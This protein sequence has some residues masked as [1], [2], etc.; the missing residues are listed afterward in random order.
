[1]GG[2]GDT[3]RLV[4]RSF[5]GGGSLSEG[6]GLPSGAFRRAGGEVLWGVGLLVGSAV[7][8]SFACPRLRPG[9][10]G[11]VGFYEVFEDEGVVV[12]E[13]VFDLEDALSEVDEV[14]VEGF[15]FRGFFHV[16]GLCV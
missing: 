10:W 12:I 11:F 13:A 1:M 16:S 2:A 8:F 15:D 9:V 5:G 4:H 7:F 6:A 3:R 14:W